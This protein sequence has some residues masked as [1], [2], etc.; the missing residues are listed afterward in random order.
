MMRKSMPQKGE[1]RRRLCTH[2]GWLLRPVESHS[3]RFC[4]RYMPRRQ[5]LF[6]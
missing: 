5:S 1:H 4:I 2:N 6:K 3:G